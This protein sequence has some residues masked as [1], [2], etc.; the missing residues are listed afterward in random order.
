MG[1]GGEH[2]SLAGEQSRGVSHQGRRR[3][4]RPGIEA[5]V[6]EPVREGLRIGVVVAGID[7][8][9]TPGAQSSTIHQV[10]RAVC[11]V[12]PIGRGGTPVYVAEAV[13]EAIETGDA[14][15]L[16]R[17]ATSTRG[18]HYSE[19]FAAVGGDPSTREDPSVVGWGA[20]FHVAGRD[21]VCGKTLD[22]YQQ[23]T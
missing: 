17:N 19:P 20:P 3:W 7:D 15:R 22:A 16:G 11:R 14:P 12:E 13:P 18:R 2:P 1:V 8:R 9:G 23:S 10:T 5:E 21:G 6:E 4:R